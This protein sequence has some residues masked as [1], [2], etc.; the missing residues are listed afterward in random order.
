MPSKKI[1]Y[2]IDNVDFHLLDAGEVV[3]HAN[4]LTLCDKARQKSIEDLGFSF[5][6]L[7]QMGMAL[8]VYKTNSKYFRPLRW[9]NSFVVVTSLLDLTGVK[10]VVNQKI[11][12]LQ[13]KSWLSRRSFLSEKIEL[14]LTEIFYELDVT[15]VCITLDGFKTCRIPEGLIKALS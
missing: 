11:I 13:D 3:Y 2:F 9:E 12:K 10:L 4:Y 7:W 15:L 6:T 8:A 14:P 1:H 5:S